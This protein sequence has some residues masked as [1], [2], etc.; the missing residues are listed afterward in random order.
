MLSC[1]ETAGLPAS[2]KGAFTQ[3]VELLPK[4]NHLYVAAFCKQH[5]IF[6]GIYAKGTYNQLKK[7]AKRFNY[8]VLPRPQLKHVKYTSLRGELANL[9]N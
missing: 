3:F 9:F 8:E 2:T 7:L 6:E 4:H 1:Y 5:C